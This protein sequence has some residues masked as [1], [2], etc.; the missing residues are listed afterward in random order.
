MNKVQD[1][2]SALVK[3]ASITPEKEGDGEELEEVEQKRRDKAEL[4]KKR[5][6]SPHKPSSQKKPKALVTKLQTTLT[7]VKFNFIVVALNDVVMERVEKQET[8]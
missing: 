1:L 4:L 2:S 5:K 7:P 3:T 8:K 6:G